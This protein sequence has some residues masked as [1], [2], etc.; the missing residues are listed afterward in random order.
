VTATT[1]A[2]L[3][4]FAEVEA[5]PVQRPNYGPTFRSEHIVKRLRGQFPDVD[6]RVTGAWMKELEAAGT[7]EIA[8]PE[9]ADS[10][11]KS[12]KWGWRRV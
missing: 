2:R 6:W 3:A 10:S 5:L 9:Q 4:F 7:I 11:N 8:R 12:L 1:D